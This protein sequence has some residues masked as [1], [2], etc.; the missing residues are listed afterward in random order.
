[1]RGQSNF[2]SIKVHTQAGIVCGYIKKGVF[3][4]K[5]QTK[6]IL[7]QPVPALALDAHV[8][9]EV[10]AAGARTIRLENADTGE[11]YTCPVEHFVEQGFK[12]NR[13][14]GDQ[15][16]LPLAAF[17]RSKPGGGLKRPEQLA[18]NLEGSRR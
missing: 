6:H 4:R 12:L 2:T 17:I 3:I 13:G 16:A 8:L 5:F 11:V 14:F 18:L 1:M 10:Q 9:A 7:R 15:V